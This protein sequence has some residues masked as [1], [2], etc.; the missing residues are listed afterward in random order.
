MRG[1]VAGFVHLSVCDEVMYHILDLTTSNEVWYK[2]SV[3]VKD[4][5]E[6]IVHEATTI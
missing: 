1:K 5:D 4:V 3:Y 2:F 6:Q